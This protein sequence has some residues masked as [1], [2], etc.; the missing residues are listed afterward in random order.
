MIC[1]TKEPDCQNEATHRFM[2]PGREP[3]NVC[4]GCNDRA[5]GISDVMGFYLH[6]ESIKP[7]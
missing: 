4:E 6:S 2:W 1:E 5:I 7:D 3:L